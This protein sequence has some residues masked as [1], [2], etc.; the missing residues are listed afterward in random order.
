ML[1][2]KLK[3][4][5][6][7]QKRMNKSNKLVIIN[8]AI[9]GGGK[10]SLT[11][12]IEELAKSLEHSISVHSTEIL[13]IDTLETLMDLWMGCCAMYQEATRYCKAL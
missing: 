12:Q 11:K 2:L 7:I 8:R 3:G 5:N 9:P 13:R 1:E 4:Q 6:R 10:I